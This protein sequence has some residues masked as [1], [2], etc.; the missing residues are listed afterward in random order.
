VKGTPVQI[1]LMI[2]AAVCLMLACLSF[3]AFCQFYRLRM[4]EIRQQLAGHGVPA[5]GLAETFRTQGAPIVAP[6]AEAIAK[7]VEQLGALTERLSKAPPPVVALIASMCYLG[8]AFL[9]IWMMPARSGEKAPLEPTFSTTVS[10]CQLQSFAD[11]EFKLP[12][13]LTQAPNAC[14]DDLLSRLE[15]ETPALVFIVGHSDIRDLRMK[16]RSQLGDNGNLA[17]QRAQ[18]VRGLLLERQANSLR[19]EEVH[20]VGQAPPVVVLNAGANLVGNSHAKPG[21]FESDRSVEIISFWVH[22]NNL[23]K[24]ALAKN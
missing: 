24:R 4:Q 2:V 18:S 10:H 19:G 17:Y 5:G 20:T 13:N 11:G 14:F 7:L 9:A 16:P 22:A 12:A 1:L 8:F 6:A 23:G 21:D 15:R 3:L